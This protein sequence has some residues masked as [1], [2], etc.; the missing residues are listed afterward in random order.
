MNATWRL[1]GR[2]FSAGC[3]TGDIGEVGGTCWSAGEEAIFQKF[4]K[5]MQKLRE[6]Y[7]D[8]SGDA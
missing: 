3:R 6:G 5:D 8:E 2:G 7:N 1:G 4:I